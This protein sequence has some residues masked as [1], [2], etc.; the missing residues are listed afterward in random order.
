MEVRCA[1]VSQVWRGI[2]EEPTAPEP[3]PARV[4]LQCFREFVCKSAAGGLLAITSGTAA[5]IGALCAALLRTRCA[6]CG[7]GLMG[8]PARRI[9]ALGRLRGI[10]AQEAIFERGAIEAANDGLHLVAGGRLDECEALRFLGF[11]VSDHF[12][13]I[14]D[15]I[16][17]RSEERRVG[18]ECRSRWSPYH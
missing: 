15:K 16:F 3:V 1:L 17:S 2:L 9:F 14:G 8:R 13:G 6:A 5:P 10:R 18:K 7:G 4:E 12:D 11:V